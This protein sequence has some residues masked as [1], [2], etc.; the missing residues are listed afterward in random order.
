MRTNYEDGEDDK[1]FWQN[2]PG[3]SAG[4]SSLV[5]PEK[6]AKLK[7]LIEGKSKKV[8]AAAAPP[9][10]LIDDVPVG[11]LPVAVGAL[12]LGNVDEPRPVPMPPPGSGILQRRQ[13]VPGKNPA[14]IAMAPSQKQDSDER[15]IMA[16][17]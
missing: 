4:L 11:S 1:V 7:G 14:S 6:L 8:V 16:P 10:P 13:V 17:W 12:L 2:R 3:A 15:R 9:V 5:K